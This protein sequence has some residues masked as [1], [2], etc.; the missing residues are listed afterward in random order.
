MA[1]RVYFVGLLALGVALAV[2]VVG[3]TPPWMKPE[4]VQE[5]AV[6]VAIQV[7]VFGVA[8]GAVKFLLDRQAALKTFRSEML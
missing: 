7:L 4:A 8:G 3:V 2:V 1:G 5:E 6:K